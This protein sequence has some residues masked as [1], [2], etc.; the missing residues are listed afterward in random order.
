MT[1]FEQAVQPLKKFADF[2]GRA[3]VAEFWTFF[4]LVLILNAAARLLSAPL[5]F[6]VSLLLLMPQMA[7]TV[8]RLHDI[9]KSGRELVVPLAM[10]AVGPL[11]YAFGGFI[12]R[13]VMLGYAGLLLLVFANLLLMLAR[14]GSSI[15]NKYGKSPD[16]FSFGN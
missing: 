11:L 4:L 5:A 8:R 10:L 16:A 6:L 7:V 13:I 2:S 3:S 9:N 1:L 14:K 15:P 12:A